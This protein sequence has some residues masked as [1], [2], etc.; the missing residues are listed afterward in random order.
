M[1]SKHL[2]LRM[3]LR[4]ACISFVLR[5]SMLAPGGSKRRLWYLLKKNGSCAIYR[6]AQ[7]IAVAAWRSAFNSVCFAGPGNSCPG[8][9]E[10]SI[11]DV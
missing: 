4:D 6:P 11:S 5:P 9:E 10:Y 7:S 1:F 8:E 3:I 2:L